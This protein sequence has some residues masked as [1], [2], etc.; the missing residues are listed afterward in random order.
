MR[1]SSA[2]SRK[3]TRVT[4]RESVE[5]FDTEVSFALWQAMRHANRAMA[6][7]QKA[8]LARY[9]ETHDDI[10]SAL[11]EGTHYPW[12]LLA[13]LEPPKPF[14]DMVESI[15]AA[16]WIDSHGSLLAC[17]TF[18]ERLGL[19]PYLNRVL[20]NDGLALLHPKEELGKEFPRRLNE[21][22]SLA[23]MSCTP[24]ESP[25]GCKREHANDSLPRKDNSRTKKR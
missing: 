18:L 21:P 19:L 5:T 10:A 12:A 24:V 25:V 20:E 13:R 8:C 2:I 15:I 3:E 22:S 17:S 4:G 23:A 11:N 9:D 14:S 16:I 1:L 6:S 7:D